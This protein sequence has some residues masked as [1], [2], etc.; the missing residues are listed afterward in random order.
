[1]PSCCHTVRQ[2]IMRS[3][4]SRQGRLG[5]LGNFCSRSTV[6]LGDGAA[7]VAPD[8]AITADVIVGFPGETE[9]QFQHTLDLMERVKF[10][11][12]NTFRR[13]NTL[14]LPPAASARS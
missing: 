12:L 1:M 2:M 6:I 8:A 13:A 10:E 14:L 11:N 9:E 4:L 3:L 7:Q 5:F